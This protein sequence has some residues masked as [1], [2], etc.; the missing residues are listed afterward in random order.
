[1]IILLAFF[2]FLH[3]IAVMDGKRMLEVL[4]SLSGSLGILPQG[5]S[6]IE[7]EK[8]GFEPTP[9]SLEEIPEQIRFERLVRK[10][11]LGGKIKVMDRKVQEA[12][13]VQ[14]ELL[15]EPDTYE[16]KKEAHSFLKRVC[17]VIN[18][19]NDP[20]Q[21]G[22]H[23]DDIPPQGKVTSS[24]ELS[25]LRALSIFRFFIDKGQV[26][27]HRLW[28]SGYG[29]YRPVV[30]SNSPENKAKNSR[31]EIVLDKGA[32]ERVVALKEPPQYFSF[33]NFV[34]KIFKGPQGD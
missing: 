19:S 13:T 11:I 6:P 34:F 2:V 24:W 30:L 22:V 16:I 20:V 3:S 14:G 18:Q 33:K 15:F 1:M 17:E 12:L 9:A 25:A 10:N 29:Q 5:L 28:A 4:G 23:T 31:V 21:I 8:E 27:P 32:R 26:S 7:G